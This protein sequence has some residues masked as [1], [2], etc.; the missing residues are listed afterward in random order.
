M[1]RLS[2]FKPR[3]Q[4]IV[5][6]IAPYSSHPLSSSFR[7]TVLQGD[8]VVLYNTSEFCDWIPGWEAIDN[9]EFRE[10]VLIVLATSKVNL[11]IMTE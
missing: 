9:S 1:K 7:I 3:I 5:D 4:T 11:D 10:Y 6:S 8:E 2:N